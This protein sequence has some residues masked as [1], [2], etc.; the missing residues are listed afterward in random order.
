MAV[1]AQIIPS[2]ATGIARLKN[3]QSASLREKLGSII[4]QRVSDSNNQKKLDAEAYV[5]E[6]VEKRL[7]SLCQTR[8]RSKPVM[9]PQA[10]SKTDKNTIEEPPSQIDVSPSVLLEHENALDVSDGINSN[11]ALVDMEYYELMADQDPYI[12]LPGEVLDDPDFPESHGL[13]HINEPYGVD[14]G[15]LSSDDWTNNSEADYF[16][17]DGHGNVYP[18]ETHAVPEADEVGWL[19]TPQPVESGGFNHGEMEIYGD[20]NVNQRYIMYHEVQQWCPTSG[21][22]Q[23]AAGQAWPLSHLDEPL[24]FARP[25]GE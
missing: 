15:E 22:L 7:W 25:V 16:Y 23:D 14:D 18:V 12:E 2:I 13:P 6:E 3:A 24:P 17:T 5:T 4:R 1:H 11:D 10:K 20:E 21:A 9:G 8:I 19:S